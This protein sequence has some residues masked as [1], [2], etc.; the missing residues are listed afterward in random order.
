MTYSNHIKNLLKRLLTQLLTNRNVTPFLNKI[1]FY[2]MR[3]HS[4]KFFDS[5]R[6]GGLNYFIHS[7]NNIYSWGF[8]ERS[9]EIPIILDL[10]KASDAKI[11]LEIG[12]VSKHY[13]EQFKSI[14]R[15]V[16]DKYEAA[17]DV[18]NQDIYEYY[19]KEKFDFIYSISTFE[20]MDS[21]GGRNSEYEKKEAF[22]NY[23][24]IAYRNIEHV[25]LNL[26]AD[27]GRL[28]IT[29]PI[30]YL[31][32]EIDKSIFDGEHTSLPVS[33]TITAYKRCGPLEWKLLPLSELRGFKE[34]RAS[35][36]RE[37]ICV[38]EFRKKS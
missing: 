1:Y 15:T 10:I 21:D 32:C 3:A 12:N 38:M 24:S 33:L 37:A 31:N 17:H 35:N 18:I 27:R 20:H 26:L 5:G 29:A 6:G 4:E 28:V 9:I 14:K 8:S 22:G 30:G 13:Y 25:V 19:S 16:I 2:N 23:S 7:Y 36:R 34:S 11:I